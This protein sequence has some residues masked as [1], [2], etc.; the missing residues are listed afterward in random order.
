[1]EDDRKP[2]AKD[3]KKELRKKILQEKY[4]LDKNLD[5]WETWKDEPTNKP[6]YDPIGEIN[7]YGTIQE[8]V[9]YGAVNNASKHLKRIKR[10]FARDGLVYNQDEFDYQIQRAL[11]D[12][13][14]FDPYE[15]GDNLLDSDEDYD[16]EDFVEDYE[17]DDMGDEPNAEV[18]A[19]PAAVAAVEDHKPKPFS[20]SK[21][22]LNINIKY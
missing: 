16:E 9:L 6:A 11:A 12:E 15:T 20:G 1:M 4:K 7:R 13:D 19:A 14:A 8:R 10:D 3:N 21:M 5:N 17:G 2:A 22:N 18:P